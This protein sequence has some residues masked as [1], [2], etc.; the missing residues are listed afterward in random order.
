MT[1]QQKIEHYLSV[2]RAALRSMPH[3]EEIVR[4][5]SAHIRDA[6]EEPGATLSAVLTRLG[7]P[8]AL[9]RQYDEAELF[10]RARRSFS[11]PLLLQAALRLSTKGILGIVVFCCG[12]SGYL[13][14]IAMILTALAKPFFP[15]A[16]GMWRPGPHS[17]VAGMLAANVRPIHEILG[18]WYIPL[19][20][21]VGA[22]LILVTTLIV[23]GCLWISSLTDRPGP[24]VALGFVQNPGHV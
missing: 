5:I 19:A 14:G 13:T 23:R 18:W 24:R 6:A 12:V 22:L 9:A 17:V 16:I 1:D 11:P 4:E 3:S 8:E 7:S 2:F 21:S 20:L 15:A 10:K